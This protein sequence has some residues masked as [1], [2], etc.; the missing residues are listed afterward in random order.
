VEQQNFRIE[1]DLLGEREINQAC[2]YGV[3][4]L[5]AREN[6]NITGV[7]ISH[8]P[9]FIHS[10]AYLKKAAAMANQQLGLLPD[11]IAAAIGKA[12]DQISAGK[13]HDQ[14][15]V[16]VIQGG[17]GTSTNMN[18][19]EVV[20]NIALEALGYE[21]G[22]YDII[23]PLNHVNMSQSTNDVYPTAIR[24]TLSMKLDGL[25]VE[26]EGLRKS[27]LAKGEEFA[28]VLKVARTQ[29]QTLSRSRWDRVHCR[30]HGRRGYSTRRRHKA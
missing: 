25:L 18:A 2:Y 13:Y 12:C 28:D 27:L 11:E 21:K 7:P 24:L 17:A 22:R 29:L 1:H 10:L 15:V 14:F 23:H 4:T 19:N 9:R 26:M 6:Y 8:Y 20:A 5:R 16:D 30:H 3:Q